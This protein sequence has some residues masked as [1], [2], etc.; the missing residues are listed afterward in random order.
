MIEKIKQAKKRVFGQAK[1]KGG[2]HWISTNE[3]LPLNP[4]LE[5]ATMKSEW[6]PTADLK[7][8]D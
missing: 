3:K 4:R 6:F 7:N 5:I 2:D 1:N 8:E